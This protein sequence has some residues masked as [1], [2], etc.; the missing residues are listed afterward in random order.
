MSAPDPVDDSAPA[1]PAGR[2]I[3]L[4]LI[5]LLV[6]AIAALALRPF[7]QDAAR[8]AEE[9]AVPVT[10]CR[11]EAHAVTDAVTL[12]GRL[13]PWIEAR[14]APAKAGLI[15]ELSV[16]KGDAV[17]AG[18]TLLRLDDRSWRVFLARAEI[19]LREARKDHERWAQ[20]K[21]AGAVSGSDYDRARARLDLAEAAAEDAR[22]QVSQCELKASFDGEVADRTVE[23]G[24]YAK[25]GDAAFHIVCIDPLKLT[26]D[27]PERDLGAITAG[28]VVTFE[29]DA[30]PGNTCT[31]MVTF[32]SPAAFRENNAYRVEARVPNADRRL[33]AGMIARVRLVRRE[34][35]GAVAVPL[36]AVLPQK[37][38]HVVFLVREG[39]AVR[40]R[41]IL[42]AIMGREAVLAGGVEPGDVVVLEGNRMLVD[43]MAVTEAGA[44]PR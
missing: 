8:P 29:L 34:R 37:G 21:A 39:R 15:T 10:T 38:E 33:K 19:D 31:G 17:R 25:E 18:Q 41:V 36:T 27:L 13:E 44:A 11:I 23:V 30:L 26:V 22:V 14:L 2:R 5:L 4:G 28:Q 16:D 7:K 43:G 9:K 6:L 1:R 20:L 3:L 35:S 32:V 12:S 42:D 24:E 40:R